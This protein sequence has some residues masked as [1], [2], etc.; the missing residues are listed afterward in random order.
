MN[1][2]RSGGIGRSERNAGFDSPESRFLKGF[3]L[4][5]TVKPALLHSSTRHT[6]EMKERQDFGASSLHTG[7]ASALDHEDED[8][9]SRTGFFDSPLSQYNLGFA[10]STPGRYTLALAMHADLG[11]PPNVNEYSGPSYTSRLI[12]E[13]NR[14]DLVGFNASLTLEADGDLVLRDT[15]G[16][17]IFK[18]GM[19]LQSRMSLSNS[20]LGVYSLV[21]EP[22]LHGNGPGLFLDLGLTNVSAAANVKSQTYSLNT[23]RTLRLKNSNTVNQSFMRLEPD[24]NLRAYTLGSMYRWED[25]PYQLFDDSCSLPQKCQPFG[26]C[27]NGDCVGYL[28]PD[29]TK[30]A[31]SNT[32]TAPRVD[33][34]TDVQSLDFLSVSVAEYF[35]SR[36]LNSSVTS[37]EDCKSRCLQN[38]S[39]S[40]FFYWNKSSSCFMTN[41]VNTLQTVSNQSH[42]AYIKAIVVE[43]GSSGLSA[44]AIAGTVVGSLFL[45]LQV[46]GTG[47]FGGV[48]E[49]VLPD[50]RKVAVK[51]LESTGQG[52]KEFYAEVSILGTIHHW[53]LV[54]LLGF[55]SE[56][57]NKLL[58]YEHMENSSLDKWIYQDCVE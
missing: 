7:T 33:S 46:L 38:C 34:C 50:G 27:S 43:Q 55:C 10:N 22:V 23:T 25:P 20:S 41:N 52:K 12:W 53:N 30:A 5:A 37:F 58:V 54:K 51:Q 19:K 9:S 17:F 3:F 24:G 4:Q 57:L 15:D 16:R 49:G 32:C 36:Y 14:D 2:L 28:K 18:P 29:S 44:G 8:A 13:A 47:G 39:C 1:G 26:I 11:S 6:V 45:M 56:G 31:W 48:Y 35:S 40:A 21:M 42:V